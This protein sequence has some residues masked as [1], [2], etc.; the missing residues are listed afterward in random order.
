MTYGIAAVFTPGEHRRK[1]YANHLLKL[2]HYILAPEAHLP[3]FPP[4]AWGAPPAPALQLGD[5]EFSVLYSGIGRDFYAKC[6]KGEDEEGWVAQ[7]MTCRTWTVP[8]EGETEVE[9]GQWVL[10][11]DLAKVEEEMGKRM[12]RDISSTGDK[13]KTRVAILPQ[14][15]KL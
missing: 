2:L 12:R 7:R 10:R 6:T 14:W 1:G 11:A 9:G 4:A 8:A 15:V 13:T 3:P 5:A